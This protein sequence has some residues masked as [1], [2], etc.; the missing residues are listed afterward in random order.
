MWVRTHV[1]L[2]FCSEVNDLYHTVTQAPKNKQIYIAIL[3]LFP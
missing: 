1:V 2:G 3:Y